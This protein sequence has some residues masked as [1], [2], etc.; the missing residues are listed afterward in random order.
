MRDLSVFHMINFA[1]DTINYSARYL[2]VSKYEYNLMAFGVC[3]RLLLGSKAI[4]GALPF[5]YGFSVFYRIEKPITPA[6]SLSNRREYV[7]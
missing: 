2:T 5:I 4:A 1:R 3:E 7:K 6:L